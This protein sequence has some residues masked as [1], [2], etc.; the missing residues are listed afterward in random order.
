[1]SIFSKSYFP[2]KATILNLIHLFINTLHKSPCKIAFEATHMHHSFFNSNI[3]TC[4]K[5]IMDLLYTI[6]YTGPLTQ[7]ETYCEIL[8]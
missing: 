2:L 8:G 7:N 6:Q 5:Q 3:L 4:Q 1:M